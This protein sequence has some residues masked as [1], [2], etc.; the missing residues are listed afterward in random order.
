MVCD[1]SAT[2]NHLY[3]MVDGTEFLKTPNTLFDLR[4][5]PD[6]REFKYPVCD[7]ATEEPPSYNEPDFVISCFATEQL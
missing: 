6:S 4:F 7:V 1:S 2:A 5:I 3:M